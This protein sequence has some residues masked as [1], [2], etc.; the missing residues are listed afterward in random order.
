MTVTWTLTAM[1]GGTR[2]TI[3]CANVPAGIRQAGQDAGLPSTLATLAP[4]VV[5]KAVRRPFRA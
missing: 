1:P 4:F 3:R 5:P 2:V